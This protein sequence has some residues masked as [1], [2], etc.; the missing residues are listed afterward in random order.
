[1][2]P[3]RRAWSSGHLPWQR[4]RTENDAGAPS[5]A[6]DGDPDQGHESVPTCP[7]QRAGDGPG[8]GLPLPGRA[9][10]PQALYLVGSALPSL[11]DANRSGNYSVLRDLPSPASAEANSA[12]DLVQTFAAIRTAGLDL[13]TAAIVEP[14]LECSPLLDQEHLRLRGAR[15][16]PSQ[17]ILIDLVFE[18]VGGARRLNAVSVAARAL[19]MPVG[20]GSRFD[21]SRS[22]AVAFPDNILAL[23]ALDSGIV[24][25]HSTAGWLST[26]G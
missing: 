3:L 22:N 17:T 9:H 25:T 20:E 19:D 11:A 26:K 23:S 1:M 16:A 12:A 14:L 7:G 10:A 6:G 4:C 21:H 8:P 2:P 18:I 24:G 13:S 5:E 15:P